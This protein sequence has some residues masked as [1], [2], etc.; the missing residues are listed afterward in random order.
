MSKKD[1]D[2]LIVQTLTALSLVVA[3][4]YTSVKY[5]ECGDKKVVIPN[6]INLII[7]ALGL[8]FAVCSCCVSK[9]N[10]FEFGT[11]VILPGIAV[12]VDCLVMMFAECTLENKNTELK[13][14]PAVLFELFL[15]LVMAGLGMWDLHSRTFVRKV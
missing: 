15:G 2:V 13:K 4:L 6:Q 10:K 3:S 14:D 11:V 9:L 7:G 8:V 1:A 5:A 12:V